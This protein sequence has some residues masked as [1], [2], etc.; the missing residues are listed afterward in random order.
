MDY[1]SEEMQYGSGAFQSIVEQRLHSFIESARDAMLLLDE[2]G[3]IILA[4]EHTQRKTGFTAHELIGKHI[5]V[6][7]PVL[8]TQ[9]SLDGRM[10]QF[11]PH[12]RLGTNKDL[13]MF[14]CRKEGSE[15]P[16]KI[17][18]SS[19]SINEEI[20]LHVTVQVSSDNE[21]VE[22]KV[23]QHERILKET[24]RIAKIASW[25]WDA[26]TKEIFYSDNFYNIARI[27]PSS[28][29]IKY[30]DF[31]AL[32]HE[33]DRDE[34]RDAFFGAIYEGGRYNI[35]YRFVLED[36]GV[37][38]VYDEGIVDYDADGNPVRMIGFLQ[39]ITDRRI[40]ENALK[41]YAKDLEEANDV[42]QAALDAKSKFLATMSHEL[43]TPL[44]GV[45]GMASLLEGTELDDEQLEYVQ[46]IFHS[47]DSLLTIINDILDYTKLDAGSLDMS[48]RPF[49]VKDCFNVLI[50]SFHP[51]A[52]NK[53]LELMSYI[54]KDVPDIILGDERRIRQVLINLL[55]NAIKF[56][57]TGIVEA[58]VVVVSQTQHGYKIKFSVV[59]TGIGVPEN[60]LQY[61]FELFRQLDNSNARQFGG[62]GLGLA[63]C[64]RL[65][66]L[67]DGEIGVDSSEKG[68]TFWFTLHSPKVE[69]RVES[70]RAENVKEK[71]VLL[72]CKN[73][74]LKRRMQMWLSTIGINALLFQEVAQFIEA[75][76]SIDEECQVIIDFHDL[77]EES[78][79]LGRFWDQHTPSIPPIC[80]LGKE[81]PFI[82]LPKESHILQRP[83]CFDLLSKQMR[84]GVDKVKVKA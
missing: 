38:D 32:V 25:E 20:F 49:N 2:E 74:L 68:S 70:S 50:H 27:D 15:F 45:I 6:L 35:R 69:N 84:K 28:L 31:L 54:G 48:V 4:N 56:T 1:D 34:V 71:S 24:Q 8:T 39:D 80:I 59:D 66:D 41:R 13:K 30:E 64:K 7:I 52:E 72:L 53:G 14:V 73:P 26:V 11:A 16:A 46:T 36:N 21:I 23:L 42:A 60:K 17:T 10:Y 82:T 83:L 61:L 47:G 55:S 78:A 76:T 63:I 3:V 79:A 77:G 65:I 75:W 33:K 18:F 40:A 62:T 58:K 81:S 51:A 5:E 19:M 44:N 9:S 37:V 57:K 12:R 67:M 43:R 29:I 22:Q